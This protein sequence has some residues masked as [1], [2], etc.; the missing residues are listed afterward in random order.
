MLVF[1]LRFKI[2]N[3][4]RS[5]QTFSGHQCRLLKKLV[6]FTLKD[7]HKKQLNFY[8]CF[9]TF[10]FHISLQN[11]PPTHTPGLWRLSNLFLIPLYLFS[12][13]ILTNSMRMGEKIVN[14][15]LAKTF[16]F[17]WS[18]GARPYTHTRHISLRTKKKKKWRG[19]FQHA[20]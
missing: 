12:E 8:G 2:L 7:D 18:P 14:G 17:H 10:F 9:L 13:N 5:K 19:S 11:F 4:N 1:E 16:F 3:V 20:A 6:L 15:H